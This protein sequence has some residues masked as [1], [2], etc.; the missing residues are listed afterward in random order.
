MKPD[1]SARTEAAGALAPAPLV[2]VVGGDLMLGSRVGAVASRMGWRVG[3]VIDLDGALRC[4]LLVLD[5]NRDPDR[6]LAL[7]EQLGGSDSAPGAICVGA[8]VEV[9]AWRPRARRLGA[10]ACTVNSKLAEVLVRQL[11][12]PPSR[13]SRR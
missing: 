6:G 11:Q 5:M 10:L 3:P 9:A 4:R 12:G 13:G 7:L 2:G 8:H 1:L